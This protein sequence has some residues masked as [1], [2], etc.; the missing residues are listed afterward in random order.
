MHTNEAIRKRGTVASRDR[1]ETVPSEDRAD[2]C[3][4]AIGSE[5]VGEGELLTKRC[6][7]DRSVNGHRHRV[8]S[9]SHVFGIKTSASRRAICCGTVAKASLV[10]IADRIIY[11][12]KR[13]DSKEVRGRRG[14]PASTTSTNVVVRV[15][16]LTSDANVRDARLTLEAPDDAHVRTPERRDRRVR[17]TAVGADFKRHTAHEGR[18]VRSGRSSSA[19]D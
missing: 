1:Q 7:R 5:D 15:A 11:E 16:R 17:H 2:A 10:R 12:L 18:R 6:R 3:A 14:R 4:A 19:A 9:K 13:S 8:A